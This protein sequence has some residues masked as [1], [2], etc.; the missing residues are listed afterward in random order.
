MSVR[1]V[2]DQVSLACAA[3]V[4][5]GTG[6]RRLRVVASESA[7]NSSDQLAMMFVAQGKAAASQGNT[8]R[9]KCMHT[10]DSLCTRSIG[11]AIPCATV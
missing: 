2:S 5:D 8:V 6:R 9:H 1:S 7:A 10:N 4:E 3:D 11:Q